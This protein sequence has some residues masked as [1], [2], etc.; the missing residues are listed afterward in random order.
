MNHIGVHNFWQIG[1]ESVETKVQ[2]YLIV[3]RKK[4]EPKRGKFIVRKRRNQRENQIKNSKIPSTSLVSAMACQ[5][6][7]RRL[8]S[9]G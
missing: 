3:V 1:Y 5:G 9:G 4:H 7:S 2:K 6:T 8:S